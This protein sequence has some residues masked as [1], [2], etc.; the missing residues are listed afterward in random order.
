MKRLWLIVAV[1]LAVVAAVC[2]WRGNSDAAF[3]AAVLGCVA[4]FL[5]FRSQAKAIVAARDTEEEARNKIKNY[6]EDVR[7]LDDVQ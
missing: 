2:M 5:N 6:S 3:V 7:D 1:L 4:W